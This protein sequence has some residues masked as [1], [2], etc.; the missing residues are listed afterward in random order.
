MTKNHNNAKRI[1]CLFLPVLLLCL[2]GC[3]IKS[4]EAL[5]A[6]PQQSEAYYDLQENIDQVDQTRPVEYAPQH[7][8]KLFGNCVHGVS[9]HS[10]H[11]MFLLYTMNRGYDRGKCSVCRK[12]LPRKNG[13]A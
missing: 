6:L 4:P 12:F 5:Y 13:G 2:S 9:S 10:S 1:L 3:W 8:R 7:C 11:Y